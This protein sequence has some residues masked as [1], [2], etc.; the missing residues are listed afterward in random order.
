MQVE[1]LHDD[2]KRGRWVAATRDIPVGS[3]VMESVPRQIHFNAVQDAALFT[4]ACQLADWKENHK[5]E[6][7]KLPYLY[8]QPSALL[9][10]ILLVSRTLRKVAGKS[11]SPTPVNEPVKTHARCSQSH[12]SLQAKENSVAE[13]EEILCRFHC[14]NFAITDE[15]LLE[16]G[17]G[18]FPWGAMVNHSCANNCIITYAPKTQ[19]MELRAIEPIPQGSEISQPYVDVGLAFSKR[20]EMLKQHYHF[21]CDCARCTQQG[22][23]SDNNL[24]DD[25]G[26]PL[27]MQAARWCNEAARCSNLQDAIDLYRQALDARGSV[28]T[29]WNVSL[30]EVHSQLL[31]LFIDL[32]DVSSAVDTALT[33]YEFYKRMYVRNHALVGLHLYTL[34]DLE[35]QNNMQDESLVHLNEALR[36][37]NITHG[38]GHALVVGLDHQ[39][40]RFSSTR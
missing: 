25:S 23:S 12:S 21:D 36:I 8:Q 14:N 19:T 20:R 28:L 26:N 39:I 29:Q 7:P 13:V 32:G 16:I 37:L 4:I 22:S 11:P 5:I 24:D 10:D 9:S 30:L 27:L 15:L 33:I 17:A 35:W 3:L 6:C 2:P 40:R 38:S 34:G 18:C 1:L 31:T